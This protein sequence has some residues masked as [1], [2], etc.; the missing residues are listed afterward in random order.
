[1]YQIGMWLR[2]LFGYKQWFR[3]AKTRDF[4]EK[5]YDD[6]SEDKDAR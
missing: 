1:M 3:S 4:L 6:L 2:K 5:Y